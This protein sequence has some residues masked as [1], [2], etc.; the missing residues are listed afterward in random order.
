[1]RRYLTRSDIGDPVAWI[2]AIALAI[3]MA[4]VQWDGIEDHSTER[5]QADTE[6]RAQ[7]IAD[8]LEASRA[9]DLRQCQERFGPNV[10]SVE[11]PNGDTVCTDKRGRRLRNPVVVAEKVAR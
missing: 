3:G 1:M 11:L 8:Q 7:R 6:L 2:G 4:V 5:A 9:A 10:A